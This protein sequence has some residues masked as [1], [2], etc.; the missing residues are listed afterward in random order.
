MGLIEYHGYL[1][2]SGRSLRGGFG[3]LGVDRQGGDSSRSYR[4]L[5]RQ[6]AISG[7]GGNS[8]IVWVFFG[9][10]EGIIIRVYDRGVVRSYGACYTLYFR[11]LLPA[12]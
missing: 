2:I 8:G 12:R 5:V 3:L 9:V 11:A 10:V 6:G 1:L 4:I 7:Y